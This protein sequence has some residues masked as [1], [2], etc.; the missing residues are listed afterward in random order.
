MMS[1]EF[2]TGWQR[3]EVQRQKRGAATARSLCGMLGQV[4]LHMHGLSQSEERMET[5]KRLR[6]DRYVLKKARRGKMNGLGGQREDDM[7][8][9]QG[10]ER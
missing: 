4:W 6:Q 2:A 3:P 5:H 9:G 8:L 10:Q 1:V 7:C